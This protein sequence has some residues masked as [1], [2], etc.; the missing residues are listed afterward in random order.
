[1]VGVHEPIKIP[2]CWGKDSSPN[3]SNQELKKE[4]EQSRFFLRFA[5]SQKGAACTHKHRGLMNS[6]DEPRKHPYV[7]V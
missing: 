3:K 2:L 6:M 7:G 4:P 1:M 5:R